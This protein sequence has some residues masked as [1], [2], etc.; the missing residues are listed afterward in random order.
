MITLGTHAPDFSLPDTQGKTWQRADFSGRPLLVMFLSNHCPFVKHLAP[1]LAELSQELAD[2]TLGTLSAP[3]SIGMIGINANDVERYPAD[4][5]AAMKQEVEDRGYRFPYLFDQSQDVPKAYGAM[6]TPDFYLFDPD[7]ALVYHGQFDGSRPTN[8]I[9][10]TGADLRA[11]ITALL[12]GEP[13]TPTQKPSIG[14][15]IKW[16]PGNEP[17]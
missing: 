7:H 9:P 15:G 3:G 8:S 17:Y 13:P 6:C 10:V 2:G 12:S 4:S 16:R 14:C 11:A 5:P 1:A